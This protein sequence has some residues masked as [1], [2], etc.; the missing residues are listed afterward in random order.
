MQYKFL[1]IPQR[2]RE[3]LFFE[4]KH[5]SEFTNIAKTEK[6]KKLQTNLLHLV[7]R[8]VAKDHVASV[9]RRSPSLRLLCIQV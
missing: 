5:K 3:S 1:D 8:G 7:Y 6:C 2:E 4:P 9:A